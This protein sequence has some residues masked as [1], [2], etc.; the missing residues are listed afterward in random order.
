MCSA[1]TGIAS[2]VGSGAPLHS[3]LL[4]CLMLMLVIACMHALLLTVLLYSLQGSTSKPG[5]AG[6]L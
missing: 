3:M 6:V 2:T 1:A 4:T 5:G